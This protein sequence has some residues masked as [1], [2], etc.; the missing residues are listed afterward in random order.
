MY[1]KVKLYRGGILK[2]PAEIRK[3]L[4]LKE[5]DELFLKVEGY[6]ISLVPREA[7]DPIEEYS[8][9]LGEVDEDSLFEEGVRAFR[10]LLNGEIPGA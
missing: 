7:L 4:G 9:T 3:S 1:R 6:T 2:L 10:R 5:G 8:S